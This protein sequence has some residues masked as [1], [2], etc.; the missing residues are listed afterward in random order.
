[1]AAGKKL[2]HTRRLSL[3][4]SVTDN[5]VRAGDLEEHVRYNVL[6]RFGQ[7]LFVDGKCV[8]DGHFSKSHHAAI[9][10]ME[11]ELAKRPFTPLRETL[12]YQ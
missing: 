4:G 9:E 12:P 10:N 3:S 5:F 6:Y 2:H 8:H 11:R 7:A 1:M